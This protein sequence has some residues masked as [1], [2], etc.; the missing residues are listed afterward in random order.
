MRVLAIDSSGLTATV[1]VVE[2]DRTIAEYTIDYK[3]THSQTLLPMIDEVVKMVELD[4]ASIDAIAVAGGPGSFTGLRIGSATAKG[5]GL[6]LDK[7]LLHIPTVDGLAYQV[8]GCEDLICPIMDARRNQVYTGIY[9]FSKKAGRKEGTNW[10][11]PCFQ[12]L[13]MQMAVSIDELLRRL[14]AYGRPVVF[15]GDGVPV[16]RDVIDKY[17]QVPYSFAPPYMSRQRAAAV[18]ALGIQYYKAGKMETAGEHQPEYLRVSQAE[19]ERAER[20]KQ[21]ELIVRYLRAED[22]AAAA[23][24]E[25]QIFSDPWSETSVLDTINQPQTICIAAEK[26]GRLIGYMLVYEAAGE[27]E[28]VRIAVEKESRRQGAGSHLMLKLENICEERK[29]NKILLDVRESNAAARSFY[30]E[31]GFV[32]DGI[33]QN[34]YDAP[35]EDAVL[36]S[37]KLGR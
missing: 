7:P 21:A 18:G 24:M 5:L 32:E 33:R 20:E 2:E 22:A 23:E 6:A 14:N 10:V 30:E 34:F 9:T 26:A 19:R 28:I 37:R 12:V 17:I 16:H 8:Y 4:L 36:M 27:A 25:R 13:K 31:E 15:L 29:I 3:K 1:A 11:E 35:K